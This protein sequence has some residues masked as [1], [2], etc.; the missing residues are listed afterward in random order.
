A[1]IFYEYGE[2]RLSRQIARR[3]VEKRPFQTTTELASAIASS[4][5][6]KYRYG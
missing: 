4:V 2:E 3:I 6:G 1:K 5:P